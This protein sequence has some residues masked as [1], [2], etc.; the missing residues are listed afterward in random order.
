MPSTINID[1][2]PLN[3]DP[4]QAARFQAAFDAGQERGDKA[5]FQK[6]VQSGDTQK[7]LQYATA[8]GNTAGASLMNNQIEQ[9]MARYAQGAEM[10]Q[11]GALALQNIS[12]ISQRDVFYKS[13][14]VPFAR[15]QGFDENVIPDQ[16]T[17]YSDEAL[18][19]IYSMGVS[20]KDQ[21]AERRRV[22]EKANE[23]EWI[24]YP[25]G[26]KEPQYANLQPGQRIVNGQIVGADGAP[27]GGIP[28]PSTG[29]AS[30]SNIVTID[31][32]EGM[33]LQPGT[34]SGASIYDAIEWVE[35]RGNPNAVSPK[36]ARGPM[37]TMPGTLRDPGF[38]VTPA[39]DNSVAEMRRVGRDYYDAMLE[40][41]NGN[42]DTALAAYNWGPGN[43]DRAM[44]QYG[45]NFLQ[46]APEETRNYVPA[47]KA[48]LGS[49]Q[50]SP[51]TPPVATAIRSSTRTRDDLR[52]QDGNPVLWNDDFGKPVNGYRDSQGRYVPG[53]TPAEHAEAR[54]RQADREENARRDRIQQERWSRE[55]ARNAERDAAARVRTLT[56]EEVAAR[57]LPRG[58][59]AQ[60]DGNGRVSVISKPESPSA[61][62]P[63]PSG[64][65]TIL[66]G[67][68][69]QITNLANALE[70]FK[71]EYFGLTADIENVAQEYFGVGTPGQRNFWSV[72]RATDNIIRNDLFGSALTATEKAAYQ[73]TTIHPRMDPSVAKQNLVERLRL[74]RLF[75]Q[76]YANSVAAGGYNVDQITAQLEGT[77]IS[78]N[79]NQ[80][81]TQS[82]SQRQTLRP[83]QVVN[84]YRFKGGDS[85]D[86]NNWER[87]R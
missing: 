41:Y 10:Y 35:S 39:R 70:Q 82:G 17:D 75:L 8:T 80:S 46:Y 25:D 66:K 49:N 65:A 61:G 64:T 27:M 58:T 44:A 83:G 52:D 54:R 12:D 48:R 4:N 81:T 38:G 78:L 24:T 57:N 21:L 32:N 55:D 3:P 68:S 36:G 20:V 71:P 67:G 6:L 28:T 42:V 43:V 19:S 53:M 26:H 87:V 40:R 16:L 2:S 56:P 15:S 74:A 33:D 77:N 5:N 79:R 29:E 9:E 62:K 76:K 73:A 22:L 30:T 11:R 7:A 45:D 13:Q 14:I 59:V 23:I 37:Q 69:D 60:I 1:W 50:D 63:L 34:G 47:V 86:R 85:R 84:G 72:F 51:N 18:A 31:P